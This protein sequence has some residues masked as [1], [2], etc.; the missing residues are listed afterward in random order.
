ML[1]FVNLSSVLTAKQSWYKYPTHSL[2]KCYWEFPRQCR[3]QIRYVKAIINLHSPAPLWTKRKK[4]NTHISYYMNSSDYYSCVLLCPSICHKTSSAVKTITK[5][6]YSA[7]GQLGDIN[8]Q[9][10]TWHMQW[11]SLLLRIS[12]KDPFH[13]SVQWEEPVGK[14]LVVKVQATLHLM[15]IWGSC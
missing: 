13:P 3:F 5:G 11:F 15:I 7:L 8:Y 4:N 12:T 2:T 9:L 6:N 10:W 1:V 14:Q